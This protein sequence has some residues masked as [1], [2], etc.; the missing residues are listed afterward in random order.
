[1]NATDRIKSL[2]EMCKK[3][4]AGKLKPA[5]AKEINAGVRNVSNIVAL[6]QRQVE[7][8]AKYGDAATGCVP[9]LGNGSGARSASS[10]KRGSE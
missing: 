8:T 3:L 5:V 1:M 2:D 7:L 10:R 4:A 9:L 6:A